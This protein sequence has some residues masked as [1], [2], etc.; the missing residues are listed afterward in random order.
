M[1]AA[2]G[3]SRAAKIDAA[4]SQKP[5][6]VLEAVAAACGASLLEVLLRLPTDNIRLRPGEDFEVIWTELTNW[7]EV[8][9]IVHTPDIVLECKGRLPAGRSGH[10]YFNIHGDSPIGGHIK[11]ANCQTIAVVDRLFH[12]RRSCS[13]QF[14]NDQGNAM[15]KVFVPRNATKDLNPATLE[16]FGRFFTD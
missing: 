16:C 6:G 7:G 14:L 10:G 4:L 1:L 9:L 2:V 15:F 3:E 5:D 12:G 11:A 13:I 8:L